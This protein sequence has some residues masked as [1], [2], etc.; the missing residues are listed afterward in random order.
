MET[1][2][3]NKDLWDSIETDESNYLHHLDKVARIFNEFI[4]ETFFSVEKRDND[5]IIHLVTINLAKRLEEL[6]KKNKII[7]M[8]S[9]T[10]HSESVLKNIFGL[11]NFKIIEAETQHQG[12]LIPCRHGYEMNCSYSNFQSQKIDSKKYLLALSKSIA[13]AKRPTLVHVTSFSDLPTE[14]QK[15]EFSIDNIPTQQELIRQQVEDPFGQKIKDFKDGKID[16]IF[17]TKCNRGIDFPGEICNSIII[18]RFPYPNISSI[19]WKILKKTKPNHFMSFY[20]DKA[21]RELLQKIYRGLRSKNDKV[22]L[23]SPDIRV[24]DFKM[25]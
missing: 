21:R 2:F 22:Y 6:I 9:G 14:K 17:T 11:E 19:F 23:L 10:I 18:T 4:G 16:I 12:E 13:C 5:L 20:M 7:I 8:M 1:A 24:L 15:E 3:E 25:N